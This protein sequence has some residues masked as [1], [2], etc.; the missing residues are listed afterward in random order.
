MVFVFFLSW[1]G[2]IRLSTQTWRRLSY[3]SILLRRKFMQAE[4]QCEFFSF[5]G[6]NTESQCRRPWAF[7]ST[8][9]IGEGWDAD[10]SQIL[11]CAARHHF[12]TP[13]TSTEVN[14]P[15][16]ALTHE[17]SWNINLQ[18]K[19]VLSPRVVCDIEHHLSTK[20]LMTSSSSHRRTPMVSKFWGE[21]FDSFT[22]QLLKT[23]SCIRCDCSMSKDT[24][25]LHHRF[26]IF[27][28]M[29]GVCIQHM[30]KGVLHVYLHLQDLFPQGMKV[31]KNSSIGC[32]R[33]WAVVLMKATGKIIF[34][35]GKRMK[36]T[37]NFAQFFDSN[38][39]FGEIIPVKF[40]RKRT[41]I[42]N[43]GCLNIFRCTAGA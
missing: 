20:W 5:I 6:I 34:D 24:Y 12:W 32:I 41:K 28:C 8:I 29:S 13:F 31:V 2:F 3:I 9:R 38:L 4:Y 30:K 23:C 35:H 22:F 33:K 27:L 17:L 19:K 37:F 42:L 18:A 16:F 10:R 7:Y 39:R 14:T 43:D 15:D 1:T 40:I 21:R 36:K 26:E 11:T 25:K